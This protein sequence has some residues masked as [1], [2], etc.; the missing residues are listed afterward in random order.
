MKRDPTWRATIYHGPVPL[1]IRVYDRERRLLRD[2]HAVMTTPTDGKDGYL[3]RNLAGQ[4][5][6]DEPCAWHFLP[7][8]RE[9]LHEGRTFSRSS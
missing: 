3:V 7:A 1:F 9:G 8:H 2:L 5:S 6:L 4:G